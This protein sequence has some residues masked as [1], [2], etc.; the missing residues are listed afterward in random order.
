MGDQL[1]TTEIIGQVKRTL[2]DSGYDQHRKPPTRWDTSSHLLYEDDYGIV[3]IVVYESVSSLLTE[4]TTAQGALVHVMSEHVTRS[5]PKSSE[6]YLVLLTGDAPQEGREQSVNQEIN[7]IR[8]NTSRVRKLVGT[9]PSLNTVD[10]VS[11]ILNPLLPLEVRDG[12]KE[13]VSVLDLL[14]ELLAAEDIPE[15]ITKA[16]IEAHLQLNSPIDALHDKLH[17]S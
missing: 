6:G 8:Y 17:Q 3:G 4:W 16:V 12:S 1:T 10:D 5:Q 15:E 13:E 7:L 11:H 9:G 14:P 2:R